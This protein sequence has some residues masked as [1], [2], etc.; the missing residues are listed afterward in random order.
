MKRIVKHRDLGAL[1]YNEA[2][3]LQESLQQKL[4]DRKKRDAGNGINTGE[5]QESAE[6][7]PS[8][9]L[10]FVEHPH[11]YTIGKSG[12][13]E[14]LLFTPDILQKKGIEV[15]KTDRGG[16]ITYHGPG[17]LVGYPVFDLEHFGTGVARYIE[18]LEEVI[19]RTASEYGI[20]A[21]RVPSRTGVWVGN[22]KL[23][24]MGIKCSRYVSMH[25]FALNVRTD[26]E[27]YHGIIPCGINDGGVTSF[28]K[29][30]GK[31]PSMNEIKEHLLGRFESLFDCKI[32]AVSESG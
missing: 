25:G 15:V 24:A 6:E 23:C 32:D 30:L 12:K 5:S 26:L 19:I 29:I 20:D 28:E 4:I 21:G 9:Y 11:V 1:S 2:W 22:S 7:L 10:L 3:R 31:A 27:F 14:N 17:Q 8:G 16:D 18:L 13:W